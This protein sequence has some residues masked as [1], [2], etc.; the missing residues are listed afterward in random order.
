MNVPKNYSSINIGNYYRLVNRRPKKG[1]R[2]LTPY[3]K[4][5]PAILTIATLKTKSAAT[6]RALRLLRQPSAL[7][8]I[9]TSTTRGSTARGGEV[10]KNRHNI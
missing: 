5:T 4:L 1:S 10:N 8:T 7:V 9:V 2:T 6:I 3:Y